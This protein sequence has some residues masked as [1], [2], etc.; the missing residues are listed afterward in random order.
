MQAKIKKSLLATLFSFQIVVISLMLS[1]EVLNRTI[2]NSDYFLNLADYD[3][4]VAMY[5]V[6]VKIWTVFLIIGDFLVG[7]YFLSFI[8]KNE[9]R[10]FPWITLICLAIS[11][12]WIT[13]YPN[14][15]I[16]SVHIASTIICV[17]FYTHDF[18]L[19]VKNVK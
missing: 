10:V 6:R 13:Y 9:K 2:L 3:M 19:K 16:L 18:S 11:G 15:F 5:L 4:S 7:S 8:L 1:I 12:L 14:N 17:F